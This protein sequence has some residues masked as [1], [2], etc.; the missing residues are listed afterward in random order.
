MFLSGL[1]SP[2]ETNSKSKQLQTEISICDWFDF[3]ELIFCRIVS[4]ENKKAKA[5][6]VLSNENDWKIII[7]LM[8][9][10]LQPGVAFL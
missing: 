4:F 7:R 3:S 6:F 2:D 1:L 9:Y 10:R 5:I 8:I